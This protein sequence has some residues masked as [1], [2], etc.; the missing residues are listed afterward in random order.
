LE[1]N[2]KIGEAR[3]PEKPKTSGG[4]SKGERTEARREK[5]TMHL[6]LGSTRKGVLKNGGMAGEKAK[7]TRGHLTRAETRAEKGR[8]LR[9]KTLN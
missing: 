5:K 2:G 4:A 6:T 3:P 1:K 9:Q 7:K 8:E